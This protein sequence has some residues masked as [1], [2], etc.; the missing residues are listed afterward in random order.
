[1]KKNFVQSYELFSVSEIAFF[2]LFVHY[3][4]Y[5]RLLYNIQ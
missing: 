2:N 1:M 5:M 4:L 3:E